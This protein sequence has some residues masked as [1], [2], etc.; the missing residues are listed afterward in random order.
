M[1]RQSL[2]PR[3]LGRKAASEAAGIATALAGKTLGGLFIGKW[4][5]EECVGATMNLGEE[6]GRDAVVD[7]LEEAMG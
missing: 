5:G 6:V 4:H 7:H 2:L 1:E 3:E